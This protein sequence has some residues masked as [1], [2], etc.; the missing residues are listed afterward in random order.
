MQPNSGQMGKE[1]LHMKATRR[2]NMCRNKIWVSNCRAFA[3]ENQGAS[4]E[5]HA[6]ARI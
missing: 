2:A 1:R 5:M 3:K 4:Q 6:E